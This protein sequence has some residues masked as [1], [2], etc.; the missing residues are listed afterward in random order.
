MA[1]FCT[2]YDYR[3][4][5]LNHPAQLW[6]H[7]G[8]ISY[9]SFG[10]ATAWHGEFNRDVLGMLH[11]RFDYQGRDNR[12]KSTRLLRVGTNP[13]KYEGWDYRGRFITMTRMGRYSL[14]ADPAK[15]TRR[16]WQPVQE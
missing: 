1:T 5:T 16:I 4:Q 10:P 12:L 13:D 7:N 9:V 15:P 3:N 8:L 14:V 6:E 11:L 2:V